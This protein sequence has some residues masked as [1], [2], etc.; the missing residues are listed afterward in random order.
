[1]FGEKGSLPLLTLFL[2]IIHVNQSMGM[3][4]NV[5]PYLEAKLHKNYQLNHVWMGCAQPYVNTHICTWLHLEIDI[6]LMTKMFG[7]RGIYATFGMNFGF[8]LFT[9]CMQLIRGGP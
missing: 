6:C 2:K 7:K 1:M 5:L 8:L 4:Y 9:N 3:K